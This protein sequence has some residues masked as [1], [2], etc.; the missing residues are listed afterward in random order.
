VTKIAEI[1]RD[2]G[3]C[4][5]GR[6][7]LQKIAYLLS[8]AGLESGFSFAYKHFGPYSEDLAVAA[9]DEQLLGYFEEQEHVASWGGNYS[10]YT[11]TSQIP[12]A[13]SSARTMFSA[14]AVGANAIELELAATAV[15]LA[16]NGYKKPWE[17][18]ERRKPEKSENGRL[19]GAK[20]L[21]S[22]LRGVKTPKP[23][24]IPN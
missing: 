15:F 6:T 12:T 20:L 16:E 3:G 13:P 24:P 7:R 21:L 11:L 4:I 19:E 18:T 2:S 23:L 22:R 1:I 9:R 8:V 17:E 5:V 10:I 14:I